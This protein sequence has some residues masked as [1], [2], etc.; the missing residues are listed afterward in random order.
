MKIDFLLSVSIKGIESGFP[1]LVKGVRLK[2]AC[3]CF[4]GS[5]PSSDKQRPEK[6]S[7]IGPVSSVGRALDF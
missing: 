3:I 2:I 1:S 7:G 4:E 6:V 5:N